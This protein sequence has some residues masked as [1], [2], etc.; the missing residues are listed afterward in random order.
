MQIR[1]TTDRV[2]MTSI[3]YEGEV[4]DLPDEE[5]LRMV[6]AGQ[7]EFIEPETAATRQPETAVLS[8]PRIRGHK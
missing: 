1:L 6:C 5:A 7:A 3:Q 2:L 8:R 4:I